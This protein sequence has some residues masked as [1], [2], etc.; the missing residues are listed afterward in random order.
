LGKENKPKLKESV[1]KWY[2]NRFKIVIIK[3]QKDSCQKIAV[4]KKGRRIAC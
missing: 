4:K 1:Q 2:K 3:C